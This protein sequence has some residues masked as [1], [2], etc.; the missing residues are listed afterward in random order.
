MNC[1]LFKLNS[2][3][4]YLKAG[5]LILV[6]AFLSSCKVNPSVMF[7][8]K[9]YKTTGQDSLLKTNQ[10]LIRS[11]DLLAIDFYSKKGLPL[12]EENA[13]ISTF[14]SLTMSKGSTSRPKF[15][16]EL[17]G[18]VKIP[19]VGKI[20]VK[21]LSIP[22]AEKTIEDALKEFYNEP[23]VI[24]RV[25]NRRVM[26]FPGTGGA[27]RVIELNNE[28]MTL[29]EV[30]ALAGGLTERG[31]SKNIKV[32]R[33][34]HQNPTVI[35]VNLSTMDSFSNSDIRIQADDIIYVEPVPRI[36]QEVLSQLAPVVGI[37]TSLA[38]LYQIAN[39][40]K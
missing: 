2:V 39:N 40:I 17:D 12:I 18:L 23:F 38:L 7:K 6:L 11:G 37:V 19:L 5:A 32:I 8:D 24:V 34:N 10:Y 30:L 29:V 28:E 35:R 36:S 14:N 25:T 15:L 33:G 13:S 31:K 27:G 22:E 16:V 26:V 21:G 1:H 4:S 20:S 9:E 3:F